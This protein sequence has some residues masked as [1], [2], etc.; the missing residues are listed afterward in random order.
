MFEGVCVC[1]CDRFLMLLLKDVHSWSTARLSVNYWWGCLIFRGQE[2]KRTLLSL[3]LFYHRTIPP[4]LTTLFFLTCRQFISRCAYFCLFCLFAC[5]LSWLNTIW[6]VSCKESLCFRTI[7]RL[8]CGY[9]L[10]GATPSIVQFGHTV[11]SNRSGRSIHMFHLKWKY[12]C[13]WKWSENPGF[14]VLSDLAKDTSEDR[15]M[16]LGREKSSATQICIFGPL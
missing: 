16:G 8:I 1:V 12:K 13:E 9:C 3:S 7:W 2:W 15:L 5:F 10:K 6:A 11:V 14:K 4:T